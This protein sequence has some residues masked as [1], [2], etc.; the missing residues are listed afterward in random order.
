MAAIGSVKGGVLRKAPDLVFPYLAAERV[1]M[2]P[3]RACRF[4]QAALRPHEHPA[5]ESLLEFA[6]GVLEANALVDHLFDELLEPL[7]NHAARPPV[8]RAPGRSGA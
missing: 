5:D 6:D 4:C 8:T 3:E 1:A 2:H 7:G